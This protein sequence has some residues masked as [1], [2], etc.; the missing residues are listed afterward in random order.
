VKGYCT[1]CPKIRILGVIANNVSSERHADILK[2][3]LKIDKLPPLLG[4]IPRDDKLKLPERHLG[5][6]PV[7][8]NKKTEKWFDYL[9]DICEKHVEIDRIIK[10]S[11]VRCQVSGVSGKGAKTLSSTRRQESAEIPKFLSNHPITQSSNHP[12]RI[13]IAYDDAFNFYYEDNFDALKD[14][15]FEIVFFSPLKDKAL[16]EGI[17]YL[18]IGGG[19][20]EIFAEK[21]SK[22]KSM[23]KSVS[24][25]AL[26]G[27][28]VFAECGG[29]MYLSE[30]IFCGRKKYNMAGI[31]PCKITME[32]KLHSLGYREI[33]LAHNSFIGKRDTI[34]RGHE[35]HWSSAEFT[36]K[37]I[38]PAFE[39]RGTR[40][41]SKWAPAGIKIKNVIASYIHIHFLSNPNCFK[42]VHQ[43]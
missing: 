38:T 40:K 3:S 2:R 7:F 36:S 41:G 21:L 19:F 15:G 6:I 28:P 23:L 30:N 14:A 5:L 4:W 39:V 29:F 34:L 17:E 16:P 43:S 9:A 12:I 37:N 1:Y 42:P 22:N 10:V 27:A 33:R 18:Y 35:F 20:P 8:E 32:P 11:G 24:E 31:L 26:S 13:G 25:F